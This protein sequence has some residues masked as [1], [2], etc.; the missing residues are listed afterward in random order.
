MQT[1][2]DDALIQVFNHGSSINHANF[3]SDSQLYALSHD[4]NFSIYQL[5]KPDGSPVEDLAANAM[6]DLREP[7]QCEY[8]VDCIASY[9]GGQAVLGAGSHSK[10]QL[11]LVP[12]VSAGSEIWTFD[13]SN[14]VSLV[15]GH[16]EEIVRSM[17]FDHEASLHPSI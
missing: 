12:I 10:N 16:G 11:D 5:D 17:F 1:D 9:G 7:L 13:P 2:E 15:G 8:V 3:L 6:G 14:S 4:E